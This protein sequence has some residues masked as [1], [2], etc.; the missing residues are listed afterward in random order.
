MFT[1][2][3][4]DT[5][6]AESNRNKVYKKTGYFFTGIIGA[7]IGAITIGLTT[8]YIN[9]IKGSAG[10]SPKHKPISYKP[11]DVSNPQNMIESAK[12][13]VVG[14]INYKQNANSFNTQDQSEEAGS[15]SGVIYKKNGNKAFIVTNNHVIDGANKVEVKLNNGKKVPAKVV[16][17]DSLLDLAVLEI[18]G[19]DVKRV[20]TLG[21]SEKIRTGETVIAIGNPLGLE[22]SVTKGIISSKEREIPVSTLGD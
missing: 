4:Y 6:Q 17:T 22:G 12:E 3:H 5:N 10:Q 21:D 11:E 2:G 9:E 14:V 18:D 20:A 1:M 19:A 15:G 16:G 13:V 7:V 8:P